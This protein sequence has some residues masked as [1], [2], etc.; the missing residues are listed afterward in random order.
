MPTPVWMIPGWVR[1]TRASV[2]AWSCAGSNSSR[3]VRREAWEGLSPWLSAATLPSSR[4]R[5]PSAAIQPVSASRRQLPWLAGITNTG[6]T[7]SA[8]SSSRR[9]FS[10]GA[11][12]RSDSLPSLA[13][14]TSSKSRST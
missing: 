2:R 5:S 1:V 3:S 8:L 13:S 7:M 11:V 6:W 9:R 10:S 14:I 12:R 4:T